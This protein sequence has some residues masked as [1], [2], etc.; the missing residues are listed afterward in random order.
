MRRILLITYLLASV[1]CF[2]SM[3]QKDIDVLSLKDKVTSSENSSSLQVSDPQLQV[4]SSVSTKADEP[5]SVKYEYPYV[6]FSAEGSKNGGVYTN[7]ISFNKQINTE[8]AYLI[9]PINSILNY[10]DFSTPDWLSADWNK[11]PGGVAQNALTDQDLDVKYPV[12]GVYDFPT[13][14][15]TTSAGEGIFTASGKLKVG[16]KAE[17]SLADMRTINE[18]Y[19]PSYLKYNNTI[20]GWPSGSNGRSFEGF[21]NVF[22]IGQEEAKLEAVSVYCVANPVSTDPNRELVMKVYVPEISQ[23]DFKIQE[24]KL[25]GTAKLK[26]SDIIADA[27]EQLGVSAKNDDGS[28]K[29]V[30]GLARFTFEQPITVPS[31]FFVAVSNFGNDVVGGDKFIIYFDAYAPNIIDSNTLL[32]NTSWVFC[33]NILEAGI[34]GWMPASTY[35]PASAAKTDNATLMICPQLDFGSGD[36]TS[37]GKTDSGKTSNMAYVNESG[38][39]LQYEESASQVLIYNSVGQLVY[40]KELGHK[41][42]FSLPVEG[43]NKG[44]YIVKYKDQNSGNSAVKVVI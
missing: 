25:L 41:G 21:G 18:T 29:A 5:L 14:K 28:R 32:S 27:D 19:F 34:E 20:Y 24:S 39:V 2:T 11:I 38:L 30:F 23:R 12:A 22:C 16:G 26:F 42:S 6:N 8:G 31:T 10:F 44:L 15:V 7:Y 17:V 40:Q 1:T 36:P 33:T 3:A 35:H 13:V 37:I 43:W 4:A 9:T